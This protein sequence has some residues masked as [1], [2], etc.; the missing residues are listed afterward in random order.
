MKTFLRMGDDYLTIKP[1]SY[2]GPGIYRHKE[3]GEEFTIWKFKRM[4]GT[5]VYENHN[6]VS[7]DSVLSALTDAFPCH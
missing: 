7:H 6:G 4:N 5:V 3:T 1:A 2:S